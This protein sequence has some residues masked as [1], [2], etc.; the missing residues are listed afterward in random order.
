MMP[1]ASIPSDKEPVMTPGPAKTISRRVTLVMLLGA[2]LLGATSCSSLKSV[3]GPEPRPVASLKDVSFSRVALT[4]VTLQFDVEVT[5]PYDVALPLEHLD[6]QLSAGESRLL[7]GAADTLEAIPARQSGTFKFPV[8]VAFDDVYRF[9]RGFGSGTPIPYVADLK[10]NVD[11]PG[12]G[13][14]TIP[15]SKSGSIA[16]PSAPGL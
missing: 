9:G 10:L 15:V 13:R 11:A 3:F 14:I 5:N 7:Q 2:G 8:V 1:R 4:S 6:Y 16:L 12:L